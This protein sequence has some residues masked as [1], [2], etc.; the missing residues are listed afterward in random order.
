MSI[1]NGIGVKVTFQRWM[2]GEEPTIASMTL[3]HVWE[4]HIPGSGCILCSRDQ[5]AQSTHTLL[6]D[7]GA[8]HRCTEIP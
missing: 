1:G 4:T 3:S 6:A 5:R 8:T 2:S 7:P